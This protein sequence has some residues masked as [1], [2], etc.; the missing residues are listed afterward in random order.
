M[1]FNSFLLKKLFLKII[2]SKIINNKLLK[3]IKVIKIKKYNQNNIKYKLYIYLLSL[4]IL[5]FHKFDILKK[6][7]ILF[8]NLFLYKWSEL[9]NLISI[10]ILLIKY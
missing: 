6:F 3:I 8:L 2:W 10:L 1:I 9:F 4:K 7:S 5:A